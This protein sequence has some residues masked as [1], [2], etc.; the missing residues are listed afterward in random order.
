[1]ERRVCVVCVVQL[2]AAQ[3]LDAPS[4]ATRV[5]ELEGMVRRRCPPFK[6]CGSYNLTKPNKG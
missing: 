6:S 3:V 1:M 5:A 2:T 4:A